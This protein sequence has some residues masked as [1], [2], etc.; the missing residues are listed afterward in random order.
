MNSLIRFFI[1]SNIWVAFC[2]VGFALSSEKLLAATNFKLSIFV[3]FA[4]ILT[5]NF[6]R[7]I[8][9]RKGYEHDHKDWQ[10]KNKKTVSFLMFLSV[11]VSAHYF[12]SF[13]LI[14]QY[15]ILIAAIISFLYPLLLRQFPFAK[16]FVIAFVWTISTF[17]LVVVE[18][19]ILISQNIIWH[20]TSRFLLVFAITI[21]FDIRDLNHDSKNIITIPSFFGVKRAKIIAVFALFVCVI[22]S[23]FQ[24]FKSDLSLP[25][26]L[27]LIGLY[28]LTFI[29]IQKSDVKKRERYF[30][31]WGESLAL[32]GYFLLVVAELIF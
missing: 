6:H 21:P 23:F 15:V 30:S 10:K 17:L 4:T 20:F 24:F 27:A 11:L 29:F 1:N 22:I 32:C 2:V 19:N 25:N 9:I 16:I 18:N 8:R 31:F 7:I 3:F 13:K 14:T 26:L 12:L 5:Y 28:V